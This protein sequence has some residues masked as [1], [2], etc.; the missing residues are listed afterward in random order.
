MTQ[1]RK[2]NLLNG[3]AMYDYFKKTRFLKE[4]TIVPFN[5]AM[6]YGDTSLKLFSDEF[7]L[8]RAK[9]HHVTPEQYSDITLKPLKP[10]FYKDFDHLALWFDEDMFCQINVLTILAWLDLTDYKNI[11]ELNIVGDR[12]EFKERFTLKAEGYYSIYKQVLIQKQYPSSLLPAPLKKGVELYLI[13]LKKDSELTRYIQRF[14]NV[15]E[16]EL[17]PKLIEEFKE[18]GLGD[19]QYLEMIR[20]NRT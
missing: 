3:Q 13:Y 11:I 20:S 16:R 18:Y 1:K 12:F 7:T 15:S 6:C 4:E 9:V 14:K 2:L 17:V 19:T 8:I 10:F 5:E